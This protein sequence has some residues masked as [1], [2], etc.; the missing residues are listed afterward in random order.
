[1]LGDNPE[2]FATIIK[3]FCS[4]EPP[5]RARALELI[6]KY[7]TGASP[8]NRRHVWSVLRDEVNRNRAF[9]DADWSLPPDELEKVDVIVE[10][11]EPE[12]PVDRISWLFDDWSPDLP[13]MLDDPIEPAD[14]A[15]RDA[16]EELVARKGLDGVLALVESAK[17]PQLVASSFAD[18]TDDLEAYESL[19]S[20]T[21]G[22]GDTLDHFAMVLSSAA[23]RR[24]QA[25]WLE[26]IRRLVDSKS[27]PP[28]TV[29]TLFLGWQENAAT[30]NAVAQLGPS[31]EERYWRRKYSYTPEG[32]AE[33]LEFAAR[34]YMKF[35][36]ASAGID[37]LHRRI[38]EAPV[39]LVF[40]LLDALVLELNRSKPVVNSMLVYHLEKIFEFLE[41]KE[42]VE[43][44]EIARREYS[45][46]PLFHGNKRS[47]TLHRMMAENPDFYVSVICDAFKA[48]SAKA[49]DLTD[50]KRARA[51]AG[52]R[53]L[54]S[55]KTVPGARESGIDLKE[56]ET[57][58]RTVRERGAATD[59]K[60]IT[61]QYVGHILAHAPSDHVDGIWPDRAIR[62]ALENLSSDDVENGLAIERFNMRGAHW[63][64][65][66]E[67][68]VQERAL[69]QQYRNWAS[70]LVEWPRASAVLE[71]IAQG[72]D[73]DAER[74]DIEA[75]KD[76]MR[77]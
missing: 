39:D 54:S 62:A 2:R 59:R 14:K 55:F 51:S 63:K 40:E 20:Q 4:F 57:W 70:A 18:V 52:Y 12:N 64:Q 17:L 33:D 31:V 48:A 21:L 69:A 43:L 34:Q 49:E 75:Q 56:L 44:I 13:G 50:D 16:M 37:A 76:Q 23:A 27:W 41:K 71:K 46:L 45:Y 74:E 10:R 22:R 9:S 15:R 47:L 66:N 73:R 8:P 61:D 42:G 32:N 28:E 77:F 65:L 30:W 24:S 26:R 7:L 60:R 68:G 67:G 11:H 53:L 72:Y 58:M 19:V 35:G 3:A 1:M 38:N 5:S 25:E 29:A 6:D 36:R